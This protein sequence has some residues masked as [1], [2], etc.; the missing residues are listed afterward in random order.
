MKPWQEFNRN[1]KIM[2]FN[3]LMTGN[4]GNKM[5]DEELN[6]YINNHSEENINKAVQYISKQIGF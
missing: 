1:Q 6:H 4:V 5:T 3:K 2:L